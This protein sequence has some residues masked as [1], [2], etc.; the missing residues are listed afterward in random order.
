MIG[1][2]SDIV[3]ASNEADSMQALKGWHNFMFKFAD[4]L[5]YD[6]VDQVEIA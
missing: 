2:F 3:K 6:A 4:Q 1:Y 5:L